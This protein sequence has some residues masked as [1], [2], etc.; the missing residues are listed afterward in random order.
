MKK[1]LSIAVVA[2]ALLASCAKDKNSISASGHVIVV[3]E[4]GYGHGDASVSV[5]DPAKR[6]IVNDVFGTQNGYPLGD[7]AQ[8]LYM[9]N[10]TAYFVM[11]HSQQIVLADA[12]HNF[13]Y[14]GNITM[15]NSS[16]RYFLPVS[17]SKAYVTELYA[18]KI[19]IINYRTGAV[20]GQIPVSGW[21]EQMV[22]YDGRVYV[23]E[24]SAPS[25]PPVHKLLMLDPVS[26]QVVNS[27]NLPTDPS[28]MVLSDEHKL[29]LLT[30]PQA[31]PAAAASLYQVEP[32]TLTVSR[33]IDF[34]PSANPRYLRYSS[35]T[36]QLL[37]A[38]NG[39]YEMAQSDTVLPAQ[40][41]IAS[42]GWNIYGLNADPDNGDIY[43]SDA[44]DYQQ[45]SRVMRYSRDGHRVDAF[46]AGIITN[47]FVFR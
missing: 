29:F 35:F 46:N 13:Q 8:S 10:D 40:V 6:S 31:S 25:G 42:A 39:I 22:M 45:A 2:A 14:L 26:D 24:Q 1:I 9:I 38:D 18:G 27:L 17:G 16:P 7:V 33:K 28:S 30:S 36:R 5:Y 44:I 19:W 34:A 11:N 41:S 23:L 43:I 32:G 3:N 4:G 20:T 15:P 37:F 47:S 12:D 21:T